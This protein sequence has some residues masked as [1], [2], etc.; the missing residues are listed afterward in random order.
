MPE[1]RATF[2]KTSHREVMLCNSGW[3]VRSIPRR[4]QSNPENCRV[5]HKGTKETDK[6]SPVIIVFGLYFLEHCTLD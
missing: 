4:T 2:S 6:T 3:V 1:V 5:V